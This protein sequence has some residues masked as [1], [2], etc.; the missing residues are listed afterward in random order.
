MC[1]WSGKNISTVL[2]VIDT[3]YNKAICPPKLFNSDP[4]PGRV[5]TS[6]L[7]QHPIDCLLVEGHDP[8][9]WKPWIS[10]ARPK[11][12][13]S[14]ILTFADPELLNK[15]AGPLNKPLCKDMQRMGY[16]DRYWYMSA[17]KYGA[18]L[19]QE[20][21]AVAYF[22]PEKSNSPMGN[23]AS[24]MLPPRPMSNLLMPLGVPKKAW[25]RQVPNTWPNSERRCYPGHVMSHIGGSPVYLET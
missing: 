10:K 18:A 6:I 11:N 15:D 23:P 1:L 17:W 24:I 9:V 14:A 3:R 4:P 16:E 8:D 5:R 2:Q 7:N 22:L 19:Q 21:L 25:S 12:R 13:P 20:R